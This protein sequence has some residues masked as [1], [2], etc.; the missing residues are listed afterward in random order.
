MSNTLLGLLRFCLGLAAILVSGCATS[1]GG[2]FAYGEIPSLEVGKSRVEDYRVVIGQPQT[3]TI[4][5]TDDGRIEIARFLYGHGSLGSA[6]GRALFLE[7]KD[8]LLNSY[9]YSSSFDD[10]TSV[11]DTGRI[12]QIER[13]TST[14]EHAI[15][16]LGEP[17]GIAICPSRA[18]SFADRCDGVE[19]VY[20]WSLV[21]KTVSRSF[22]LG[23]NSDGIVDRIEEVV[24][25]N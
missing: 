1:V 14:L 5:D 2:D 23:I 21:E 4:E 12:S 7:Y 13:G 19:K 9:I 18:P 17:T 3:V 20:A 24:V 11:L 22:F 15:E 6:A 25:G 8:G 16:T 10:G